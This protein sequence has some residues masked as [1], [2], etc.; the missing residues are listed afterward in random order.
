MTPKGRWL[1]D[2]ILL[3][4]LYVSIHARLCTTDPKE[5]LSFTS[6]NVQIGGCSVWLNAYRSGRIPKLHEIRVRR[7]PNANELPC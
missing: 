6:A 5:D 4:E 2:D 3:I 1:P 7:Q